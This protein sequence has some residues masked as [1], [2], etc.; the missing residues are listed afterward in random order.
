MALHSVQV[1][2][3][4]LGGLIQNPEVIT[5]L[6]FV[7]ERD[8]CAKPHDVIYSCIRSSFLNNEKIDTVLLAQKIKNLG[9]S[10]KEDI[11][12]FDYIES[13]AFAP[14]TPK[15][16]IEAAKELVKLRALRDIEETCESIRKH[17]NKSAHQDLEKTIV[18]VDAMYGEKI[19]SFDFVQEPEDLFSD[20][21]ETIEET[22]N[23]PNEDVG[24]IMPYPEFNRFYGGLRGGNVY[25][26]ASR[27]G[28]GKTTWLNYTA[29]EVSRLNSC[30]VLLLD[31]EMSTKEIK[32]RSA[33]AFSGVP[34]WYLETG[35][36]RKNTDYEEKVRS[37]IK[38]LKKTYRVYHYHVGNKN[39]DQVCSIIRRWYL[40]VVGRG[41]KALV[42]YDYLKLTGE[43]LSNNWAE[44]QA[45]GEKV[46]KFKR[47]H[48]ELN[49]PFLTAIQLNRSGENTGRQSNNVIDDGSAVSQSD[50]LQ[51]FATYLAIFR[52]KTEDE[53]VLD[54]PDS[55]THKLIEIKARY[56]GREAAGHQDFILRDFPDGSR[57]Y[58]RNY[59]NFDI[60]NF[61]VE[62]RGSLRD[63]IQR[64]NAQ[65]LVQDPPSRAAT[66]DT[67]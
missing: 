40:S 44:H 55:G 38:E 33:A 59:I 27:P 63:S 57:K 46:D 31:T 41:K 25:A 42:C 24:L 16:T 67:L 58:I 7:S 23:N 12:I 8:F 13:I 50:R 5:D 11:N 9:I 29:A 54:T 48:E 21:Y 65:F 2:R 64:Q 10:F 39:V 61:G 1:E 26:I 15:V 52:R 14:I 32:F 18:E 60:Q 30:P 51:W 43:K 22:G 66:E 53:L 3:H 34:L 35:N 19:D 28:Q 36:W 45:L 47:I 56:Q 49:I 37:K 17:V 62:E 6:E 20:I 4:V